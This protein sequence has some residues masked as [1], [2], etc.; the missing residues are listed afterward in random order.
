[1][2]R[3]TGSVHKV[4]IGV[5]GGREDSEEK[6]EASVHEVEIKGIGAQNREKRKSAASTHEVEILSSKTSGEELL[7]ES[8][9]GRAD[10]QQGRF[11]PVRGEDRQNLLA[12]IRSRQGLC[13]REQSRER[14]EQS[15]SR[16]ESR[17]EESRG[18]QQTRSRQ[19]SQS[20]QEESRREESRQQESRQTERKLQEESKREERCQDEKKFQQI[21][22]SSAE[23]CHREERRA[24]SAFRELKV[25]QLDETTRTRDEEANSKRKD[26][27]N[28]TGAEERRM[29]SEPHFTLPRLLSVESLIKDD[30][31]L[32]IERTESGGLQ[33]R[34]DTRGYRPS[35]LAVSVGAGQVR[36]EGNHEE[37]AADGQV[38]VRRHLRRV[39]SLP[40]GT[41]P[42]AV[43]CSLAQDGVLLISLPT[44][45]GEG[46]RTLNITQL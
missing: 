2:S 19:E 1:M 35:Q 21:G 45:Q 6:R 32:G 29:S 43:S 46:V 8:R 40:A 33:I 30:L 39:Y 12:E 24:S 26:G 3:E 10:R 25:N 16:Q 5:V 31:L 4:E 42:E 18:R 34:L 38:M 37:R 23:E 36:V 15:G 27:G 28:N 13:S 9:P 22:Q 44:S 17:R 20:R 41:R 11:S 7:T 14:R